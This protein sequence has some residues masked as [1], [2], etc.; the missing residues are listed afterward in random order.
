MDHALLFE[1]ASHYAKSRG[2]SV[3]SK[4]LLG[5]GSDGSVWRSSTPTAV[6]A[7]YY[8][9]N[10]ANELE[11]YRR[12]KRA[13]VQQINGF[14]VPILEDSDDSLY[15]VEMSIVQP[16][17]LLDFG[18]VYIDVPPPYHDD[19]QLMANAQ[20]EWREWFG[21]HWVRVAGVLK[22]LQKYGSRYLQP[23]DTRSNRA[24]PI[25]AP[26]RG[27][28][29]HRAGWPPGWRPGCEP[30]SGRKLPA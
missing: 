14:F 7:L 23:K 12:L 26:V 17:Y 2:M 8:E 4:D 13:G 16:P 6:K 9:K 24:L 22:L 25:D 15:I 27:L 11:S 28:I 19:E 3:E 29:L 1:R 21:K 20:A 5:H 18:K 30:R 10:Y